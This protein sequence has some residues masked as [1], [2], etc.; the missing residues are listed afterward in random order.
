MSI[1]S[2]RVY[3]A[4]TG[5]LSMVGAAW[6]GLSWC[7]AGHWSGANMLPAVLGFVA[8]VAL[9]AAA[10]LF[11]RFTEVLVDRR[12]ITVRRVLLPQ[13]VVPVSEIDEVVMLQSLVL[14]S[15]T[16]PNS[17]PRVVL[18]REGRTIAAFTPRDAGVMRAVESLKVAT[19]VIPTALTPLQAHRRVKGSVSFVELMTVPL[20]WLAVL[21]PV[22]VV[23]V[24]LVDAASR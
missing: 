2:G 12:A 24:V 18:R 1:T 3:L 10:L 20:A 9:A 21:V 14:P 17:T 6:F 23:V 7:R 5:A 4:L 16:L 15:R 13:Q 8:I 22:L 11:A 19:S